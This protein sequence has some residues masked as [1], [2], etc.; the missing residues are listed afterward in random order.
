[1]SDTAVCVVRRWKSSHRSVA[2]VLVVAL[3]L[4]GCAGSI[5][6]NRSF[7]DYAAVYA[8]LNNRQL[9]L[10]LARMANIHPPHFLA[11]QP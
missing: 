5:A 11:G 1:M 4:P 10:N 9:L 6:L 8:D 3:T 7:N 2:M